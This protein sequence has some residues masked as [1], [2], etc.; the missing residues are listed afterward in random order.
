MWNDVRK[1]QKTKVV[2]GY[3]FDSCNSTLKL[4]W[5]RT[6]VTEECKMFAAWLMFS[7]SSLQVD[8]GIFCIFL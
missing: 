5:L 3:A 1:Q 2:V 7:S 8:A 6:A 4:E